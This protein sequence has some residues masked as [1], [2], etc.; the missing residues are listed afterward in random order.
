MKANEDNKLR[1]KNFRVVAVAVALM[2]AMTV[3]VVYAPTLYQI[4]CDVTGFG[5]TV[6]RAAVPQAEDSVDANVANSTQAA[7]A[8][9]TVTVYFDANV[10]PGLAWEF[11]PQQRKVE[12]RFGEPARVNYYARNNSDE[13]VVARA[14][15]NVTPYKAAPYF[16]KIECFCFTEERLGPGESAEM[17]LVLYVDEQLAKDPST[18]E[19]RQITLSYTFFPQSDLSPEDVEAARDLKAGSQAI[20]SKLKRSDT[21]EFENDAPRR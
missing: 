16:F 5:G 13:A 9:E 3:L 17:P 21:V 19:V 12:T 6:Q 8:D 2:G 7:A 15:F 10:A 14:S 1:T 18:R 11:R 4:F 20:D